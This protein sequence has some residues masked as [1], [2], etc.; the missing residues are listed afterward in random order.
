M[1]PTGSFDLGSRLWKV[2]AFCSIVQEKDGFT[3]CQICDMM[4]QAGCFTEVHEEDGAPAD[5]A[6]HSRRLA[7]MSSNKIIN[8]EG[9]TQSERKG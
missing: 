6:A 8:K 4:E 1:P 2:H 9:S 3:P 7:H 5:A